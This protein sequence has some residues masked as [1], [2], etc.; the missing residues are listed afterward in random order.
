MTESDN[1]Y[2]RNDALL[3]RLFADEE[4]EH[5]AYAIDDALMDVEIDEA[6]QRRRHNRATH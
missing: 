1:K 4:A 2:R 5:E 3:D 6:M